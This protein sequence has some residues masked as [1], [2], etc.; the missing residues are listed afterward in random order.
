MT[1]I[2]KR[3]NIGNISYCNILEFSDLLLPASNNQVRFITD[4]CRSVVDFVDYVLSKE[5][6]E[7]IIISNSAI[8][9]KSLKRLEDLDRNIYVKINSSL[10][11][12]KKKVAELF[13]SSKKINPHIAC[14]HTKVILMKTENNYYVLE[15]SGNISTNEKIEQYSLSNHEESYNF[16]KGWI[17]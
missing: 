3:S 4:Q 16:H 17:K 10:R 6:T 13:E 15:G 5:K 12:K 9:I 11:I 1:K 14:V 2:I 8:D 7:E